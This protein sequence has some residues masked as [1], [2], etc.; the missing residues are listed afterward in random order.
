MKAKVETNKAA[1][2]DH[3]EAIERLDPETTTTNLIKPELK[4]NS[5]GR[6]E[7]MQLN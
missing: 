1:R 4:G 5:E 7:R 3:R 2:T 6:P